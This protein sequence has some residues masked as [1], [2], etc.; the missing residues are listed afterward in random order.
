MVGANGEV[1]TKVNVFQGQVDVV[2]AGKVQ[3]VTASRSTEVVQGSAPQAARE[4]SPPPI[5][6][7][8]ELSA[9]ALM[10]VTDPYDRS[11]GQ[12][13]FGTVSQIPRSIV[14]APQEHPQVVDIFSP[15]A[16]DWEVGIVPRGDGGAFQLVVSTVVGKTT[17]VPKNLTGFIEPGQRLVT[18]I[19]L[20]DGGQ[21]DRVGA[22]QQLTQTRAK[23]VDVGST[24]TA[25]LPQ[26]KIFAP[27][28]DQLSC[29]LA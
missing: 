21:V 9:S 12:T 18:H 24:T 10:S 23:I 13:R 17:G 20:G 2:A 26:P 1:S 4:F 28:L 16:G 15:T 27:V 7:R 22:F 3:P 29:G 14:T 8:M 6:L 11:A 25:P 19:H 5:C